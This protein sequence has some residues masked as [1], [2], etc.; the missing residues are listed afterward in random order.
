MQ[1]F[2]ITHSGTG[3]WMRFA[4]TYAD[5]SID[6]SG[7]AHVKLDVDKGVTN[8]VYILSTGAIGNS[9][10]FSSSKSYAI[11]GTGSGAIDTAVKALHELGTKHG[12][13]G[14]NL[15]SD[16]TIPGTIAFGD[17]PGV[18]VGGAPVTERIGKEAIQAIDSA[19]RNVLKLA[20]AQR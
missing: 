20:I 13:E 12:A 1:N 14:I 18:Y 15:S 6:T 2:H 16:P 5:T 8:P 3:S 17:S 11:D 19:A 7:T 9:D 10:L 4:H